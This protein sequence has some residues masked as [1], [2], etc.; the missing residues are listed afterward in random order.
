VRIGAE[1]ESVAASTKAA[2]VVNS[3]REED[4]I[5]VDKVS[6][7]LLPRRGSIVRQKSIFGMMMLGHSPKMSFYSRMLLYAIL[8][9]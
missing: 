1:I 8:Q 3:E 4:D 6:K 9:F 5:L 2:K 7:Y